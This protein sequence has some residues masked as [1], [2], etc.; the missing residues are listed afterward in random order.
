MSIVQFLR[1]LLARWKLILGTTL[2]CLV[3]ASTIAMLLPKRYPAT[4]R[5][6]MDVRQDPVTGEVLIARGSG[7]LGTQI[8]IIRDM[9][10]AGSV[11]DRLNLTTDPG[12]IARYES[13]GRSAEDGGM[14]AWLGQ[15][16]IDGTSAAM[17]GGSNILEITYQSDD[18]DRAKQVVGVIREAYIQESLRLRTDPAGRTGTWFKEQTDA[19]RKDLATAEA[20]LSD[21]MSK[22]NIIL[23]GGMDSE[24]AKLAS[25]QQALQQAQ[26]MESSNTITS[27]TRLAN[28]PVAD[29]QHLAMGQRAGLLAADLELQLPG[30]RHTVDVDEAGAGAAV[31][32]VT[33]LVQLHA[34]QCLHQRGV[35]QAVNL[36]DVGPAIEQQ[37]QGFGGV[38]VGSVEQDRCVA[39]DGIGAHAGIEQRLDI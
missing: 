12:L 30:E 31:Q 39:L 3:V 4:A 35:A 21:F 9:R 17:V 11:V 23:V 37:F 28:D 18:P 27:S 10:V 8:A 5:V 13:T 32:Q 1:I 34:R 29:L 25:L 14:R 38:L 6:L 7:Y 22:N 2:A 16:I 19:A 26:A 20:A 24:T 36:V 15:Q 33:H